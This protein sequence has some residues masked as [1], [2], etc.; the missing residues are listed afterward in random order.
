MTVEDRLHTPE[1]NAQMDREELARR[2]VA[3][4]K[5]NKTFM[6]GMKTSIGARLR[7]EKGVPFQDLRWKNKD[8]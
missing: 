3:K 2:K 5:A 7:G 8:G 4:V 1:V 6:D